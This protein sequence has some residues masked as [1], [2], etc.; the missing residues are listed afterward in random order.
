[1]AHR[2][3]LPRRDGAVQALRGLGIGNLAWGDELAATEL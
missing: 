3:D 2:Q 1:M